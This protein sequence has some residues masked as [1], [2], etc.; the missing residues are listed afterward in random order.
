MALI[1]MEES[2]Q[3]KGIENFDISNNIE[4]TCFSDFIVI[5]SEVVKEN[6]NVIFSTLVTQVA[7]ISKELLLR[8]I[9]VRGGVAIGDLYHKDNIVFGQG[10]IEAYRIESEIAE[11]PRIVLSDKLI[12]KLMYPLK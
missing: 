9:L 6:I 1:K 10:L 5:S 12:K 8:N 2:A 7:Y 3:R 11:Y 4:I